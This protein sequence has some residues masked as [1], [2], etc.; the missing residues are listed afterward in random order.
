MMNFSMQH[1]FSHHGKQQHTSSLGRALSS[2]TITAMGMSVWCCAVKTSRGKT[3]AGMI[4]EGIPTTR[5]LAC[6]FCITRPLVVPA[7][8]WGSERLWVGRR[9][10]CDKSLEEK[11]VLRQN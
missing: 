5:G 4:R 2:C 6:V 7:K 1:C 11:G 10:W 9:R 8:Y 3:V